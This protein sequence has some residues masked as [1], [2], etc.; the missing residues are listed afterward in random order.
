MS[1]Q[2]MILRDVSA[3]VTASSST[4]FLIGPE[5]MPVTPCVDH[6]TKTQ[7][8]PSFLETELLSK[9]VVSLL[10]SQ[11]SRDKIS[12]E[13]PLFRVVKPEVLTGTGSVKLTTYFIPLWCT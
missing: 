5:R 8:T 10:L 7:G 9:L 4:S 2:S 11:G 13:E 12:E 1:P 3:A 6:G